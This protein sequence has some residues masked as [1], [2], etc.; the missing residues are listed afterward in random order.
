MLPVADQD[1]R[2]SPT[3]EGIFPNVQ[4]GPHSIIGS[5]VVLGEPARDRQAGEVPTR[6]GEHAVIR[7]H[8]IIYAGNEIGD[9]FQTGHSVLMREENS[10]GSHVSIGSSSIIE[11][12]VTIASHVRIHS[13]TFVPE[14]TVL[15][16]GCWLGPHVVLTNA[17]YPLSSGVKERLTGPIVR[18]GA[19]VGANATLL[20]GVIVGRGA[21]V[22]AGAVVVRDVPDWAIVVGNPARVV[23][24]VRQTPE[25]AEGLR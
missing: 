7:S 22:G 13:M 10:I 4:L 23:G 21:L 2:L 12:H 16:E 19:K 17:R 20:P 5:F 11:H 6:I 3:R 9:Y 25:Y 24:D 14:M 1:A 15:E 18:A 8:S